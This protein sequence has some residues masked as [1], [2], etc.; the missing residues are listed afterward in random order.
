[1]LAKSSIIYTSLP[2]TGLSGSVQGGLG[3]VPLEE[4]PPV[5]GLSRSVPRGLGSVPLEEA[6]PVTGLSGS[7]PGGQ[8]S[9]T[10]DDCALGGERFIEYTLDGA[11][12]LSVTSPGFKGYTPH[13]LNP[14]IMFKGV[15]CRLMPRNGKK[16]GN[17]ICSDYPS[18]VI[19]CVLR[20][21]LIVVRLQRF[22]H[23]H[24]QRLQ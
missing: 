7:V 9:E 1:M 13:F 6:P 5:T 10:P 8:H 17:H 3:S 23:S 12:C 4:A 21:S 18:R 24:I 16:G 15:I 22:E 11:I 19:P 2:V 20:T 14:A